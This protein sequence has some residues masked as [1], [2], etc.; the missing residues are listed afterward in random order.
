MKIFA[1]ICS[2]LCSAA[3]FSQSTVSAEAAITQ[4]VL[5]NQIST[6]DE[7]TPAGS[8]SNWTINKNFPQ[9]IEQ[10]IARQNARQA[11]D[12][13]DNLSALELSHLA[14]LYVNANSDTG[15]SGLLLQLWAAK[16]D[17]KRLGRISKHFGYSS[18]YNA[19]MT[20]A[21]GKWSTFEAHSNHTFAEP[22]AGAGIVV[23]DVSTPTG[24]QTIG[25]WL[26]YTPYQI[27]LDM[28]TAP[29]GAL[30][31][32]GALFETSMALGGATYM[33]FQGGWTAGSWAASLIQTYSPSLWNTIGGTVAGMVN[34]IS[35]AGTY[36]LQGQYE[37][38][39]GALFGL[40]PSQ[41]TTMS[42]SGGDYDAAQA[43]EDY[44][45]LK[46]Q[47][48]GVRGYANDCPVK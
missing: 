18:V 27:Y 28:R 13:I 30:S 20:I 39:A 14:Q 43:W 7:G 40:T 9:I 5:A 31:V 15:R 11:S 17:G 8:E 10:N 38:S 46:C 45:H 44:D 36:V 42:S 16:L 37:K 4:Q 26:N 29:V 6:I 19:V 2:V 33:S 23:S 12:L 41:S 48:S 32:N 35:S 22:V 34:Q 47:K 21:P 24:Q 25:K 1:A 3:A